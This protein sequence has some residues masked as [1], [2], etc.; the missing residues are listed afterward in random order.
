MAQEASMSRLYGGIHFRSD[1]EQ[2][3]I[4]GRQVAARAL[5][6]LDDGAPQR[7]ATIR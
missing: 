6:R 5:A 7:A 2:G 4:V 3:L 1:N